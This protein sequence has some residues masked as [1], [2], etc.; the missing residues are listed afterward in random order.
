[1]KKK[2]NSYDII[3]SNR[4]LEIVFILIFLTFLCIVLFIY[5]YYVWPF[6]FALVFYIALLPIHDMFVRFFR[7]RTLSTFLIVILFL[8]GVII[9]VYFIISSLSDQTFEM[10]NL[11]TGNFNYHKFSS[12]IADYPFIEKAL[13]SIHLTEKEIYLRIIQF[14]QDISLTVLGR[15]TDLISFSI[16][17]TINFFFMILILIFLLQEGQNFGSKIYDILPFPE[18]L[19]KQLFKRL[20]GVI[21]ILIAGNLLIMMLQGI[22]VG[23]GF[24]IIGIKLVLI[25]ILVASVFSLIP[26]LGTIVAWGPVTVYLFITNRIFAS[27]FIAIWCLSWYQI[28]ENL[29]KPALFGKKLNFHPLLFFF[30]LLGSL[31]TFNLPGI[32]IGPIILTVFYSLWE[33][34]N[35]IDVYDTKK[36]KKT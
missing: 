25:G 18:D 16:S 35:L 7:N 11:V 15:L 1:M 32:I 2:Q 30:L 33:I 17:F 34:Y 31:K 14:F 36:I 13:N 19:E 26:V 12:F 24:K 28:L 6:L 10:Y 22:M 23:I 9:P 20:K 21:K 29:V 4:K 3:K 8:L 27:I 5:R